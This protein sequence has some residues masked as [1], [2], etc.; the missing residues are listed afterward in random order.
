VDRGYVVWCSMVHVVWCMVHVVWCMVHVV[1]CM[2]HVVWC[3]LYGA[4]CMLYGAWCMLYG[5]WCM[6][7]QLC[8]SVGF[9]RD[10]GA[11]GEG[12]DRRVHHA[13]SGIEWPM[14]RSLRPVCA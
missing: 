4:W 14:P 11:G 2:V 10:G 13:I 7:Y 1:W 12:A 8:A 6:L 3:M 5:A 9:G